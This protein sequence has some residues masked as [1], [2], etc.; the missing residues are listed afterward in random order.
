MALIACRLLIF[1][2]W[3]SNITRPFFAE[4]HITLTTIGLIEGCLAILLYVA[5]QKRWMPQHGPTLVIIALPTL[6]LPLAALSGGIHSPIVYMTMIFPFYATVVKGP[7]FS[8]I[9]TT[10]ICVCLILMALLNQQLPNFS[11]VVF[12]D[13]N[14][15]ARTYWS[16]IALL[17]A[18]F[19]STSFNNLTISLSDKLREEA[20]MDFLT[21][22]L[23]RRG[24]E[25]VLAREATKS[26]HYD[27]WLSLIL[28]DID[29]FKVF[30]DTH[31]HSAGDNVL[32]QTAKTLNECSRKRGGY[33]G[34]WGGEEFLVVLSNTDPLETK[35]VAEFLRIEIENITQN[36]RKAKTKITST[37]GYC[38]AKGKDTNIEKMLH[39]A[40][41]ALYEGKADGKN[42]SVAGHL[43][44]EHLL[45]QDVF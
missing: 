31:G 16:V 10:I 44:E 30:N 5:V 8:W 13:G 3:I 19:F 39:I 41:K 38:S 27:S 33:A 32:I 42:R 35:D 43:H 14:T 4:L 29:D 37:L 9:A 17:T 18:G 21:R 25:N 23:N 1:S 40:D 12:N 26:K 11:G 15:L 28:I 22:I 20:T 34:R 6:C 7:V 2:I 45:A 24:L 36:H